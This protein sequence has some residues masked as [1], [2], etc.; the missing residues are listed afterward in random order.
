MNRTEQ[1]DKK[2]Q[3]LKKLNARQSLSVTLPLSPYPPAIVVIY[4]I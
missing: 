3:Q 2:A 4:L 1:T